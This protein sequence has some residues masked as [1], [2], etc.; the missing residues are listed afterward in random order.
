MKK[1]KSI[2]YVYPI[3]DNKMFVALSDNVERYRIN[4]NYSITILGNIYDCLIT[5]MTRHGIYLELVDK[6]E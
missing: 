6:G 1:R 4:Q 2:K 3:N 5:G